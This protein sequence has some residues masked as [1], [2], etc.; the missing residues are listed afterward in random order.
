MYNFERDILIKSEFD[1][2]LFSKMISKSKI[3]VKR[4]CT[5]DNFLFDNT[6]EI[7]N[8]EW[9][10]IYK[11]IQND[12]IIC[13]YGEIGEHKNCGAFCFKEHNGYSCNAWI[14]CNDNEDYDVEAINNTNCDVYRK[15]INSIIE[16]FGDYNIYSAAFGCETYISSSE[17]IV[18]KIRESN[19]VAW[20][21][22]SENIQDVPDNFEC[23][24]HGKYSF[25]FNK[26]KVIST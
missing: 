25:L 19:A 20:I 4:I 22:N 14:N 3:E 23:Y 12:K 9:S 21:I 8:E 1:Q 13:I 5:I 26:K 10:E 18:E 7:S 17:S 24:N 2:K 6:V 16:L 15:I 11:L